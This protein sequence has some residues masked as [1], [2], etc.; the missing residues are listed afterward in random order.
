MKLR[1]TRDYVR[2]RPRPELVEQTTMGIALVANA[3]ARRA[4]A[5]I[6]PQGYTPLHAMEAVGTRSTGAVTAMTFGEVVA[7]GP[8]R[9]ALLES[10]PKL[11]PG[12]IVSYQRNRIAHEIDSFDE[13][14]Q[15]SALLLVH[16]LGIPCWYPEGP[17]HLPVPLCNWV[18]TERDEAAFAKVAGRMTL[19]P[20]ELEKGL[21]TRE[22]VQPGA[23]HGS[24]YAKPGDRVRG[25]AGFILERVIDFGPGS[26]VKAIA[27]PGVVKSRPQA[28]E[29]VLLGR[30][31]LAGFFGCGSSIRFR[32]KG[33]ELRLTRWADFV[34][35]IDEDA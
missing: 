16:E 35:V 10:R 22:H 19:T 5:L 30:G 24:K 6:N 17:D 28:W 25:K 3:E 13:Q 20:D 11:E 8:G 14:G 1:P 2:I 34:G 32:L 31:A 23:H 33:R 18:L 12:M 21:M 9:D 15:R 26:W 4:A 29:P 27:E 7:V